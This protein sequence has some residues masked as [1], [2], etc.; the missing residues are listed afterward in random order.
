MPVVR[1]S[2]NR[3]SSLRPSRSG[4]DGL[5]PVTSGRSLK[6]AA[7]L[8]GRAVS[9]GAFRFGPSMPSPQRWSPQVALWVHFPPHATCRGGS[10]PPTIFGSPRFGA[11]LVASWSWRS[12]R[13]RGAGLCCCEES[14]IGHLR[15]L[16]RSSLWLSSSRGC[17]LSAW[18]S[19]ANWP[20][21]PAAG[22]TS[23]LGPK[24]SPTS[25]GRTY[26]PTSVL[27][28]SFGWPTEQTVPCLRKQ[29]K[30]PRRRQNPPGASA[31]WLRD[32]RMRIL[33]D[34]REIVSVS[35]AGNYVE[36]ALTSGRRHLIRATLRAEEAR[37]SSFGVARVHRT[38]LVNVK[39]MV[40]VKWG[41]SGDFEVRLDTGEVVVGSRRF[42]AT[43]AGIV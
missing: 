6:R 28:S 12:C 1:I 10:A 26:S 11:A 18:A 19:F 27:P 17:T 2:S 41:P 3:L 13:L 23:T 5:V 20:M 8:R 21:R 43:V 25:C 36:Y 15:R 38:R 34:P 32:G 33:I 35:S 37:L 16:L 4:M 7:E 42:K 30:E 9:M 40:A 22:L 14:L 29:P 39:R 24:K 31:F